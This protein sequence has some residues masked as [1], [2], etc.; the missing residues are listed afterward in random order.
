MS[1]RSK[2]YL[3]NREEEILKVALG[4]AKKHGYTKITR[5]DIALSA[6]VSPGLVSKY[7]GTMTALRRTIM[8]QAVARRIPEIVA[9]GLADKNRYAIKA[10]DELKNL[11]LSVLVK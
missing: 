6:K 5:G 3:D 8:R 4:L 7:L 10:P 1:K 11:A 2:E 9:Q